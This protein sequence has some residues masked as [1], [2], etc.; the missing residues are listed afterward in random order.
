MLL[1]W[2]FRYEDVSRI[3]RTESRVHWRNGPSNSIKRRNCLPRRTSN[4]WR[5]VYHTI[6]QL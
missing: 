1:K 4:C 6:I 3:E 5:K 2:I